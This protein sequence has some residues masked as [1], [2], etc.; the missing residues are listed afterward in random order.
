[1][2]IISRVVQ[3]LGG[4]GIVSLANII[5]AD[6]IPL[7]QRGMYQG[8][9][10]MVYAL[11]A[12]LGPL[13]GGVFSDYASW[14][15]AFYINLPI[16]AVATMMLM[17]LLH[18]QRPKDVPFVTNVLSLDFMGIFLLVV[19]IVMVLL[20]LSWGA[21]A[22]YPWNSSII[23]SLLIVGAVLGVL[24]LLNE[25]RQAKRPIIPLRLFGTLSLVAT[26]VDV[27]LQGF[28]FLG[29]LFFLPLYYQAVH[30][31]TAVQS[32]IELIPFVIAQA[33]VAAIVGA[34]MSRWGI[35]K[36]F[37]VA[38]FVVGTI[39]GGLLTILD[40]N[41]PKGAVIVV[42][43]VAGISQGL[44]I[45]SMLL[46]IHA[47]V[48]D[49]S[50][51]A[52]GT[53]LW[54]FLRTLGGVFGIAIGSTF[55]QS[56]LTNAGKGEYAQNIKVIADLPAE[57][58]MPVL[59]AFV[60]GLH[61]FFILLAV[62]SGLGLLAS[63]FIKKVKMGSK[64]QQQQQ[65]QQ[66]GDEGMSEEEEKDKALKP[67]LDNCVKNCGY[68]FH[69]QIATKEFLNELVR[70]F[71]E[72]PLAVPTPV[73]NRI[74]ELIQ[75]WYQT[76]CKSSRYKED[77]V[78]IKD[79]H[80][81]LTYKGYRFPQIKGDS[82]SVLNP[83]ASLK[84]P[85]E[86]E[87]EDRAAQSAKLQELIR[88]GRPEDVLAANELVKK[89]TGYEQEEKPDYAEEAS[90]ELDKILQKAVLLTEML[91]DVKPGEIIG[92]GDIF[93]DLLSTCKA[94]QP[95]IQKFISEGEDDDN[96]EK[97]LQ[98]N[99]IINSA[100]EQYDQVKRGNLVKAPIPSLGQSGLERNAPAQANESSLIDLVDFGDTGNSISQSSAS[101][102][103]AS[104]TPT[105]GNLMDDLMSLNFN[106]GPPP[107]WAAAGSISLGQSISP[108][109]S[110]LHS[111]SSSSAAPPGYSAF[112]TLGS[113][114]SGLGTGSPAFA[115]SPMM[116]HSVPSQLSRPS[117][118]A[119]Q[120][121]ASSTATA[122]ATATA[123][124][125]FGD[126]DFISNTGSAPSCPTAVALLNKNGLCVDLDIEYPSGDAS[127]IKIM[128]YFS[129]SLNSPMSMLTFRVAVP[130]SLQLQLNPQSGQVIAAFSKRSVTQSM[131]I[132]NPSKQQ[133]VRIRYHIS[134]VIEGRTIE[135]QGEFNQFPTV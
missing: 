83:V 58:R 47:Q 106:D 5:T 68:P 29:L 63:L 18:L 1:M 115:N 91:N 57:I 133:P 64:K 81:L 74:L 34:L 93:E 23:L 69:L 65:Q 71:P 39:S 17:A 70:K 102:P 100:I 124:S 41:T 16:G 86:L 108:S 97:L 125:A 11:A 90:S 76:L 85:A 119:I 38:G 19:S 107:A 56:S 24:F 60:T 80:R 46:G 55:L 129:N 28:I 37:T 21:D 2:L 135:E 88:R 121:Q 53:S 92:R 42:L 20:G 131:E 104:A 98:I 14:R 112:I 128:A 126:F 9:L 51:I 49:Q 35:Y 94:A 59:E 77:L 6:I 99:D 30:G 127:L 103:A 40:E 73:Q 132:R 10:A 67:L 7:R 111:A 79:M 26:Y 45:S 22:K 72:R 15:W 95:K 61:R 3:G 48:K 36:E 110:S 122:T 50:D 134:Y 114:G 4:S 62:L 89:M 13:L 78:H 27:F 123:D 12:V 87:E 101:A 113:T 8:V 82:A 31:S 84:S 109:G 43:L 44:T 96:I 116:Q 25:W 118:P 130:K 33:L 66:K 32:G 120:T 75:E 117:T 105:T 52:F 54:I